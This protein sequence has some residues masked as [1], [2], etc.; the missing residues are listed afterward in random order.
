MK[1]RSLTKQE[2][3]TLIELVIVVAI[4]GILTA[5]AI[6]AYGAIQQHSRRVVLEGNVQTAVNLIGAKI[7]DG[8]TDPTKLQD[9]LMELKAGNA[10]AKNQIMFTLGSQTIPGYPMSYEDLAYPNYRV[11]PDYS[12][13][14][15]EIYGTNDSVGSIYVY[16]VNWEGE[17]AGAGSAG[18]K[19]NSWT[20]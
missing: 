5:I 2:G 16:G 14:F 9:A 8:V 12:N 1:K 17:W 15:P 6:P 19:T 20:N 4:I 13:G 10:D 11:L 7:A 18:P 3:F